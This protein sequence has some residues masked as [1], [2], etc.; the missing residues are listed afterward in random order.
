MVEEH[1]NAVA[2]VVF[3]SERDSFARSVPVERSI[4]E[5]FGI[6]A[7]RIEVGPLALA[8]ETACDSVVSDSLFLET[9][10]LKARVAVHEVLHDDHHLD[11]EFPVGILLLTCLGLALAVGD[12]LALV[13]HAML[14]GPCH[15]LLVLLG[16]VDA[17]GHAADDFGEVN[18]FVAHTEIF[19]EEVGIDDTSGDAHTCRTHRQI[20]L[21]AHCSHSLGGTCKAQNLLSNVGWDRVVLKVLDV[22]SVDA[23]SRQALLGV[24]GEHG[25]KVY[26]TR[27]LGSVESPNSLRPMRVH[28]HSLGAIAPARSNGD[29]RT[30]AL[31]L[32]LLGTGST[33][34]DAADSG[35]GDNALNGRTVAV[36]QV[37]TNKF[38]Y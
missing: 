16:V 3:C 20:R 21:A 29:S 23:E 31:A 35:V 19:L 7:V 25:S 27:A 2:C 33:L 15:S 18:A 9:N 17:L 10:L 28:V 5:R 8:L 12:V 6:V 37:L 24:C 38:S 32:E 26:S 22:V 36:A 30:D 11:D 14:A 13:A 1:G 4:H 34:A